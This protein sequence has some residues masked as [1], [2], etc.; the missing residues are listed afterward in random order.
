M[1][2][3]IGLLNYWNGLLQYQLAYLYLRVALI[4]NATGNSLAVTQR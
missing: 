3:L 2:S 1:L 4:R